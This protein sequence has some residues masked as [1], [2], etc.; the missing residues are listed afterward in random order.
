[1]KDTHIKL[2]LN[3]IIVA[4]LAGMMGQIAIGADVRLPIYTGTVLPV[5]Q[6]NV[7]EP[8]FQTIGQRW[9]INIPDNANDAVKLAQQ[10]LEQ[11]LKEQ[12]AIADQDASENANANSAQQPELIITL[13]WL[14]K[15]NA[16]EADAKVDL[17]VKALDLPAEG[18][19]IRVRKK[20]GA[21]HVFGLGVDV[22]GL[23]YSAAT[24]IQ[25]IGVE[26]GS[27]GLRTNDINDWPAWESRYFSD[28]V[29]YNA[30]AMIWCAL[31][32]MNG[33]AIQHRTEWRDFAP[34]I[35]PQWSKFNNW[36]E[37][38]DQMNEANGDADLMDYMIVLHI[39]AA[40]GRKHPKINIANEDDIQEFIAYCRYAAE[41]GID[42]ILIAADDMTRHDGERYVCNYK[43]EV[44]KFDD[45]VGKAHGYLVKR[46]YAALHPEFPDLEFSFCPAPYS[47]YDH[48]VP[49][50]KGNQRYLRD[51]ARMLPDA[52]DVVWTGP[53]VL[54]SHI[55]KADSD[56]FRKYVG[57]HQL[58]LWDNTNATGHPPMPV[59]QTKFE[60]DYIAEQQII[61]GNAHM[62]GW[63]WDQP[64]AIGANSYLWNPHNY[65]AMREHGDA[66]V[67]MFGKDA[68]RLAAEFI[69]QK[70]ALDNSDEPIEKKLERVAIVKQIIAQMTE[71]NMSTKYLQGFIDSREGRYS[72]EIP[73][74][75]VPKFKEPIK[76]DGLLN[77][78]GWKVA[79][80]FELG[81]SNRNRMHRYASNGMIGY[82]A[83]NLYLAFTVHHSTTLKPPSVPD[84]RDEAIYK[85]SDAIELFFQP[86]GHED[87]AHMVFDFVGHLYDKHHGDETAIGLGWNPDWLVGIRRLEEGQWI[88]EVVIPFDSFKPITTQAPTSGTTW[89]G[90][91]CR[92]S[93]HDSVVS[94]WSATFGKFHQTNRFGYLDFE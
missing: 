40:R 55:S 88:A 65:D 46:V 56:A 90:N 37:A 92:F 43:E 67:K 1:M 84:R 54:S 79:A 72:T 38:L 74:L 57:G 69:E 2:H 3:R 80:R 77:D 85:E 8:N 16:I 49:Q 6:T 75:T 70:L 33:Y 71:R 52:V 17:N 29:P 12:Q 58:L 26:N 30:S 44:E 41:N 11:R 14:D 94:N 28:Y 23:F 13:G 4:L 89:R 18:Y 25:Q 21:L 81:P 76:A 5:V 9:Q 50:L 86:E 19:V 60:D 66:A 10:L 36:Q 53:K 7:T 78:A 48:R 39:Y 47:L 20:D 42:H 59:W 62:F 87:Y 31:Y 24:L 22:R 34:D 51:M 15:A 82:D 61:Y 83:N 64:Y 93:I 63:P 35:K 91:F 32:K 73:R 27:L 68:D 45:S